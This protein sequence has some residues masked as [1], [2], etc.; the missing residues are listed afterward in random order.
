MSW[1]ES[2]QVSIPRGSLWRHLRWVGE[3]YSHTP[4][5]PPL[6]DFGWSYSISH[7]EAGDAVLAIGTVEEEFS[8]SVLLRSIDCQL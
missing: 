3:L 4:D 5:H 7:E 8:N 6:T 2:E 1:N